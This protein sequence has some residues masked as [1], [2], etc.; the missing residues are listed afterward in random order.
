MPF[1]GSLRA[2]VPPHSI[3]PSSFGPDVENHETVRRDGY[4][5]CQ[6]LGHEL[7]VSSKTIRRDID[8]MRFGV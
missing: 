2:D 3:L 8:S 1:F 4:P 7:E 5:N 6:R